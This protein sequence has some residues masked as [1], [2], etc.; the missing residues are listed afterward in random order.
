MF[1]RSNEALQMQ[2]VRW[3]ER[4]AEPERRLWSLPMPVQPKQG[5]RLRA[6]ANPV[7]EAHRLQC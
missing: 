5:L 2:A 4:Q 1:H 3:V 6:V 7:D